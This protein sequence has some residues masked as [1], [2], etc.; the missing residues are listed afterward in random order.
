MENGAP[1]V[2]F[3]RWEAFPAEPSRWLLLDVGGVTLAF[4]LSTTLTAGP[5]PAIPRTEVSQL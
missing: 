2:S 5:S 1:V 3:G 4:C